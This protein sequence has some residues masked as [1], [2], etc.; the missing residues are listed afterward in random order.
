MIEK[1]M[2]TGMLEIPY[3]MDGEV[4]ALPIDIWGIAGR[5][6]K[7]FVTATGCATAEIWLEE[8]Q[9]VKETRIIR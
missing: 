4:P 5:V 6:P 3:W 8:L 1:K 7:G 2:F 9:H